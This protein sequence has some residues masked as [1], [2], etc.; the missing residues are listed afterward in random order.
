MLVKN[1]LSI[2]DTCFSQVLCSTVTNT[3]TNTL[4]PCCQGQVNHMFVNYIF[5]LQSASVMIFKLPHHLWVS[6]A[7]Y[8]ESKVINKGT[9][10]YRY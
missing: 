6:Y 5:V 10:G 4:S 9:V 1:I 8:T 2:P 3:E 7:V